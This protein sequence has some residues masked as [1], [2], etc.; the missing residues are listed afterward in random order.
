MNNL[1]FLTYLIFAYTC[2]EGLVI[3]I[4]YPSTLPF[5]FKDF[6]IIAAYLALMTDNRG[7]TGTLRK[8]TPV[9]GAFA[10]LTLLYLLLPSQVEVL[11]ML[12]AVK[13][14]LLYIPLAYVGYH[15]LRDE[16]DYFGLVR[17]M[18]L[19][20]IPVCIFGIYLYFVGPSG[21]TTLGANYSAVIGSTA[22]SHG[23]SFWRVP[24]T[25]T[26]P[27]QFGM[28]L[29]AN[30]AAFIGV[31]FGQAVD[32][33]QRTLTIVA[34]VILMA[35]LMVSGSRA[36]LLMLLLI[37]ATMLLVTGRL[38][39]IGMAAA[40]AYIVFAVA[41]SYFGG[42]VE[43]RVG[44]IA[45][46]ENVQ[47]FQDTYFGQLF[48]QFLQQQPMGF[49][50]GRAT[51]GARHFNQLNNVML[52]ESYFGII[53]AEMGFLG[54]A[55][56]GWLVIMLTSLLLKM[57]RAMKSSPL[58]MNWLSLMLF[59][60]ATIALLPV[61]TPIDASPGNLYFWFLLGMIVKMHDLHVAGGARSAAPSTAAA[62][63]PAPPT[64]LG[65]R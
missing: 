6:A 54:L 27:G 5:L 62:P 28:F 16:Q 31:L 46:W 53:A 35:A 64:Y 57:R 65:F 2:V 15:F 10:L 55:V 22:G 9:F 41:F 17:L 51:V 58:I 26:S 49:G 4:L 32:K 34:T 13:Q 48:L 33:K 30:G 11:G 44:S 37:A 63:M 24:A 21:L 43:D 52:V 23:I 7:G 59:V 20:S 61:G 45:S 14:R 40:G 47:R 1:R 60:A 19:T 50:L 38:G 39:G 36:P 56:F 18:A 8:L 3:N 25:F 29:L 12:V 42:G